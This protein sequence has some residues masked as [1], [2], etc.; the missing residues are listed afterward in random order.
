M[1]ESDTESFEVE[2]IRDKR[3]GKRGQLGISTLASIPFFLLGKVEYLIKWKGYAEIENTWEPAENLQCY[4]MINEFEEKYKNEPKAHHKYRK[5]AANVS[6]I[7]T[8]YIYY[9][10]YIY[11]LYI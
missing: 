4:G 6:F 7:F 5:S 10:L 9:T 11:C 2:E 1:V 3:N 8:L